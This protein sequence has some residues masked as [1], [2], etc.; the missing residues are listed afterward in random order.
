MESEAGINKPSYSYIK[1]HWSVSHSEWIIC[2]RAVSK[3]G[4]GS[5][6]RKG[7]LACWKGRA[8][9]VGNKIEKE[10]PKAF[11]QLQWK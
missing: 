10:M 8:A 3:G 2:G 9:E 5:G 7:L 1:I 11:G 6:E 4:I